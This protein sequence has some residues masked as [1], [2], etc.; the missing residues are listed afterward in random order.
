M[1]FA[2]CVICVKTSLNPLAPCVKPFASALAYKGIMQ[3]YLM[4]HG[5]PVSALSSDVIGRTHIGYKALPKRDVNGSNTQSI[6]FLRLEPSLS[7]P[8]SSVG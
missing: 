1:D 6:T 8:G 5:D 4:I 7:I 2:L 3:N